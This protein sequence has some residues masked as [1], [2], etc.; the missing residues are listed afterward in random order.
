MRERVEQVH[1][2]GEVG[3]AQMAVDSLDGGAVRNLGGALGV[4][5]AHPEQRLDDG[6]KAAAG[7]LAEPRLGLVEHRAFQPARTN[8]AISPGGVA[9]EAMERL[10]GRRAV[11]I[12]VA[13]EV[14]LRGVA[15]SFDECA[16]FADWL[17]KSIF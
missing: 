11:S 7:E 12:H 9:D 1:V 3:G 16:A 13:D 6:V 4:R 8:D 10:G 17:K 14:H 2:E 15:E 5:D